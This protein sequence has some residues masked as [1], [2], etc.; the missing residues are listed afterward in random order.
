MAIVT[1][2]KAF[3]FEVS[4]PPRSGALPMDNLS[5]PERSLAYFPLSLNFTVG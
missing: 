3:Y 1:A 2:V 5:G 4:R